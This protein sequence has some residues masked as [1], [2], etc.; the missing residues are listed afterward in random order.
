MFIKDVKKI[1]TNARTY[2]QPDTVY[3]KA[4]TELEDFITP[5]LNNLKES[6]GNLKDPIAIDRKKGKKIGNKH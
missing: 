6:K 5:S 2:N 3:Y 4:A 1:F